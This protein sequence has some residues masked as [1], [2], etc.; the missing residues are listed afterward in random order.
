M[1][2]GVVSPVATTVVKDISDIPKKSSAFKDPA[3]VIK[4]FYRAIFL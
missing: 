3:F 2:S 1:L 4:N